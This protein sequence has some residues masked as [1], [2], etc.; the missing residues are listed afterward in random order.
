MDTPVPAAPAASAQPAAAATPA[1][2]A[3]ETHTAATHAAVEGN[4]RE[5]REARRAER[6]GK[7]LADVPAPAAAAPAGDKAAPE[8]ATPA[9]P[10]ERTISKRQEDINNRIREAVERATADTQRELAELRA[11]VAAPP[12]ARTDPP[13][14]PATETK[15]AEWKRLA[16]MPDAP[17]LADFDSVEEHAAA[18]AFFVNKTLH[19]ERLDQEAGRQSEES[20][21]RY[22]NER[23]QEYGGRLAAAK[24]ADPDIV[25]KIAPA[26]M[27]AR[28]LSGL[29][30]AERPK[31]TFA[32]L[33]AE[34]GLF[35]EDPAGLYVYLSANEKEAARIASLPTPE[36][37]LRALAQLD[38]RLTAARS[39]PAAPAK[40]TKT[41]TDAPA[42]D[43]TVGSR[44]SDAAADP[45][46][47]AAKKGD[48]KQ[49]RAAK[50][51]RVAAG[52]S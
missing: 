36:A 22:L 2:A 16:S 31:A 32:N 4:F 25:S 45:V 21:A 29:S 30:D 23:G 41:L 39:A 14:A 40:T 46:M 1:P 50:R 7:P 27:A 43:N 49:F 18:M 51:A 24:E 20:R 11:R 15:V 13:A 34:T 10:V 28:P 17:K 38:G 6:A 48:F 44:A 3:A 8:S 9:A 26:I 33:V 35:S 52:T 19:Q 5:F 42:P 47:A 12:A 37:A